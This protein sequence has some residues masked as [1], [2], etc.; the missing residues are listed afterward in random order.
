MIILDLNMPVLNG[1]QT[2]ERLRKLS[3]YEN[4]P[5]IVLTGYDDLGAQKAA[6]RVGAT[7]FLTKPFQPI[8]MLD[9]LSRYLTLRPGLLASVQRDAESVRRDAERA[10]SVSKLATQATNQTSRRPG[11]ASEPNE[12]I[13]ARRLLTVLRG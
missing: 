13:R 5:V 7:A 11:N 1:L 2:C 9:M 4:T 12:F 6:L 10:M 8:Q 3:G